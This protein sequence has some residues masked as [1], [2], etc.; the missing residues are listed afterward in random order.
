VSRTAALLVIGAL[1]VIGVVVGLVVAARPAALPPPR[2]VDE[3]AA[4]GVD[5]RYDGEF[6]YFVGGGVAVFDCDA[7]G[8]PDLYLAGGSGPASLYRNESETGGALRFAAVPGATTDLMN[9]TGAYPL[10][11]DGDALIDLAVLRVGE[12]MLLRGTG[13]C[14]FEPANDLWGFAGGDDWSTAF[15]ATWEDAGEWPTIAIGNYLAEP[16]GEEPARCADGELVRPEPGE[17]RFGSATTLS[18]GWCT[19]SMLF[20]DWD[21]SGRRDLRV[22]NDRHYYGDESGGEEQLWRI[23]P[24]EPPRLYTEDEGWQTVRIW[25]MGIA[26]QDVTDDGYPD[27][28]LTSQADNK[29]QALADGP[30]EPRFEDIAHEMGA[31]ATRPYQGDTQMPSTAW[32]PEFADVN[33]DGWIDLFV[34]KGNVEAQADYAAQDPSNLLIGQPDGTFIEGAEAAGIVTFD[35]ARGAAVADLNLDGLLDLVVVYRREPAR[36]WRNV[37]TGDGD[38]PQPMGHWAALRLVDQGPNSQ[39]V[40]AWIEV[41]LGD[42]I[43]RH[44]VTVGG[45][46]VS[47]EAGWIHF[48]L[49][50]ATSAEVRVTW[51]DGEVGAWLPL[52]ADEFGTIERDAVA[53]EP[54]TPGTELDGT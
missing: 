33:N 48:G 51:P 45:G 7:D 8:R 13:E 12:N 24:G 39:A 43:L 3:T 21:R 1:V 32:H 9:V 2:Y 29:L 6:E 18:P 20:S 19:L 14:R 27:Y 36:L 26:G 38:A 4:S 30:S 49:G 40:G 17:R 11:V 10:D 34:S 28:Y 25:G 54:W 31:T 23:E 5:H 16:P 50:S 41:M 35:R 46:H 22:S 52:D 47:G 44:E 37:G 42:R 53:V 15:S